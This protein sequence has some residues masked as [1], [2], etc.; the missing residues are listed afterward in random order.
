MS[1]TVLVLQHER[2]CPP[3]MIVP[4]LAAAGLRCEV[5]AADEASAVPSDL[6]EHAGLLVLGGRMGAGDDHAHPHLTS[7]KQLLVSTVGQGRPVLGVCLGHQLTAVALG[8]EVRRNPR[9]RT[10]GLQP[11]A[12]TDE[13]RSDPLT[14]ALAA[15]TPV[16]HWNDDVVTRLPAGAVPLGRS[17]D[18]DVQAARFGPRAWGV[19]FHPEVTPA[20][21]ERW[22]DDREPEREQAALTAVQERQAELHRAWEQLLGRFAQVVLAG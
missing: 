12:P 21:V 19:Q 10:V 4:W 3:A 6:G 17:R 16:L 22:R 20:V 8:G 11:W 9:G 1:T 13:G 5:R 15:G 2:D 14:G 7:T 18:G